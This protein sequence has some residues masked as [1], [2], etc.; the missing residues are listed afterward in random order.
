VAGPD[1]EQFSRLSES[2]KEYVNFPTSLVTDSRG[3]IYIVDQYGSGLAL[4]ARDGSFQG[5]KL[6]SG[7]NESRLH[8][9]SQLCI[10]DGGDLFI[11]DRNNSRVQFFSVGEK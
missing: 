8:Y 2:L 11:A 5:R 4:L 3:A 6:G 9:P 1:A 10:S 7:W